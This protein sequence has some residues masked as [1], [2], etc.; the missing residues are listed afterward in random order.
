M[1]IDIKNP[2]NLLY[3]IFENEWDNIFIYTNSVTFRK[4]SISLTLDIRR[5]YVGVTLTIYK[6]FIWFPEVTFSK[7]LLSDDSGQMLKNIFNTIEFA[8]K[9]KN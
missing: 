3:S 1:I 4:D 7:Y 8:D 5:D 2:H 9:G 6:T